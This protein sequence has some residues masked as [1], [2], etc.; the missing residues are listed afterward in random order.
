MLLSSPLPLALSLTPSFPLLPLISRRLCRWVWTPYGGWWS[1]P[2]PNNLKTAAV[3]FAYVGVCA[4]I[5]SFGEKHTIVY[6]KADNSVTY[7]PADPRS[8]NYEK[9]D[10]YYQWKEGQQAKVAQQVSSQQ[11]K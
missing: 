1:N 5:I 2:K 4:S 9:K 11:A 8:T 3:I 7:P 6:R 10:A